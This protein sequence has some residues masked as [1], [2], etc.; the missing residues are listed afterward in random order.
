[1][2]DQEQCYDN[3]RISRN[4]WDTNLVKVCNNYPHLLYKLTIQA[5]PEYIAVNWESGGGGAFAVIP[6]KER[7]RIPERIPLFRGH[8]AVVLDTDW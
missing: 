3:L 7:G 6:V 4:A 8:T 5:N 1:M 2:H